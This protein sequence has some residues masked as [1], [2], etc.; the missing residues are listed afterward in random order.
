MYGEYSIS[1]PN[2]ARR[3]WKAGISHRI[4]GPSCTYATP[5]PEWYIEGKRYFDNKSYQ[6]AAGLSDE[7][8]T[9]IVMKYGNIS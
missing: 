1:Y 3:W 2:G 5:K 4:D 6:V 9:I 8:M 7:D